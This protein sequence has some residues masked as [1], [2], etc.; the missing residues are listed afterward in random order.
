MAC[1]LFPLTEPKE[2]EEN[3]TEVTVRKAVETTSMEIQVTKTEEKG[4]SS[5]DCS[6]PKTRFPFR[7]V[8]TISREFVSA[9]HLILL[10]FYPSSFDCHQE[11]HTS[12]QVMHVIES[13][14]RYAMYEVI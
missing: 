2:E 10:A 1:L 7:N 12:L 4:T 8:N 5:T 14:T 3:K 6:T 9:F 13:T 11:V